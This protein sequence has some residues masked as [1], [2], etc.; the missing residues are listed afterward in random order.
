MSDVADQCIFPCKS[1]EIM[2]Q[3]ILFHR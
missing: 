2:S 1:R 3:H